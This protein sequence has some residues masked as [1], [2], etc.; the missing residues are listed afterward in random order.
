[1][2]CQKYLSVSTSEI[3]IFVAGKFMVLYCSLLASF[4]GSPMREVGPGNE[5]SS[6]PSKQIIYLSPPPPHMS[7][8]VSILGIVIDMAS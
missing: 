5:V 7:A 2:R 6:L 8:E 1:M 4:P 3:T